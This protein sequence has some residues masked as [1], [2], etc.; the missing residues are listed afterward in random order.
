MTRVA[1]GV[2]AGMADVVDTV[3]VLGARDPTAQDIR[4]PAEVGLELRGGESRGGVGVEHWKHLASRY[5][6]G[7]C[8][9]RIEIVPRDCGG[10]GQT[11]GL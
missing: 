3:F 1:E 9:N 5:E 11:G 8:G 4:R 7:L 6:F 10:A 2:T